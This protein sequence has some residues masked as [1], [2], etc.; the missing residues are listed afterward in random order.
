MPIVPAARPAGNSL[1][2]WETS[3]DTAAFAHRLRSWPWVPT[4]SPRGFLVVASE[5]SFALADGKA[6]IITFSVDRAKSDAQ[7]RRTVATVLDSWVWLRS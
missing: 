7:R 6:T 1:D 4:I 5:Q 2:A 3:R